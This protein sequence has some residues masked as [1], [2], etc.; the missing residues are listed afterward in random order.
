MQEKPGNILIVV[1]H[2]NE[3]FR[4]E[5]LCPNSY[6]LCSYIGNELI[7][8]YRKIGDDLFQMV[9]LLLIEVLCGEGLF[10]SL[11]PYGNVFGRIIALTD[12]NHIPLFEYT[13][14]VIL[15]AAMADSGSQ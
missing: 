2:I 3:T 4:I 5:F 8:L 7:N 1:I 12:K 6:N 9:K 15:Q 10:K 11:V 14:N 13:A